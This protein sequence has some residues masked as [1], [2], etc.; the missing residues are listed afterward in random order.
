MFFDLRQAPTAGGG[1][2]SARQPSSEASA[3][4]EP[5]NQREAAEGEKKYNS[6]EYEAAMFEASAHSDLDALEQPVREQIK[7]DA[8]QG[9]INDIHFRNRCPGR[10][11]APREEYLRSF[12]GRLSTTRL[13]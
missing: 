11:S 10:P 5:A 13:S 8:R 6:E 3:R 2:G 12:D 7:G 9:E 4:A 1:E